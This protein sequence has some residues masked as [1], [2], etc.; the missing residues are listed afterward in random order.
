VFKENRAL[1]VGREENREEK[2][3]DKIKQWRKEEIRE[4]SRNI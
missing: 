2:R 1:E 4:A 3:V